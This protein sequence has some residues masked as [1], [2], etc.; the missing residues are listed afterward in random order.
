MSDIQFRAIG[1]KRG[2][3][4]TPGLDIVCYFDNNRTM[5]ATSIVACSPDVACWEQLDAE[6]DFEFQDEL[7]WPAWDD[8]VL[9][10]LRQQASSGCLLCSLEELS[11]E[12]HDDAQTKE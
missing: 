12:D 8:A 3:G 10:R 9:D 4:R 2:R 11:E 7:A 6:A 5:E 1:L